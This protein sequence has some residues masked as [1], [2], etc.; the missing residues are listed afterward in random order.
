LRVVSALHI[1][2]AGAITDLSYG[3]ASEGVPIVAVYSPSALSGWMGARNVSGELELRWDSRRLPARLDDHASFDDGALVAAFVG[4]VQPLDDAR[5]YWRYG[6]E[7]Q[8]HWRLGPGP[9]VIGARLRTDAVSGDLSYV[10]FT[11][12]P[13]LGGKSVLRG[14]PRDRFRDRIAI[15]GSLEYQWDLSGD[16]MAGLFTDIGRVFPDWRETIPTDLRVGYGLSLQMHSNK[17]F[18]AGLQLASSIDGGFFVDFA[19]AP[20]FDLEPRVEQR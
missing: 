17:R 8:R 1:H 4:H 19:L 7:V 13:E 20:A 9:R 6:G 16:L 18:L 5:P 3:V 12:L 15:A 10:A 14:Y 2:A 11:Q